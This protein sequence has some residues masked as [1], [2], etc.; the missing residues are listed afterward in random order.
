LAAV[1]V[2]AEV[3]AAVTEV[4][5]AVTEVKAAVTEVKAAV[6]EVKAVAEVNAPMAIKSLTVRK[7]HRR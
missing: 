6:T 2:T 4:K 1:K 7:P 5:A 3:K